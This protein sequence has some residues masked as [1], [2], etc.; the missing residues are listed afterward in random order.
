MAAWRV[1]RA[2]S[3]QLNALN[4][5]DRVYY[6]GSYY[7]SASE[8]HVLPGAGRSAMLTVRLLF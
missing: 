6:Q 8:N 5:T 1:N 4:L 2:L 7:T 3:L